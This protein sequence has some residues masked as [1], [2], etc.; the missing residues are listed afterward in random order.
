MAK[1]PRLN[2]IA[3]RMA[4]RAANRIA[5]TAGGPA[6]GWAVTIRRV[7]VVTIVAGSGPPAVPVRRITTLPL[8]RSQRI[9]SRPCAKRAVDWP[10][11]LRHVQSPGVIGAS[12][13][14]TAGELTGGGTGAAA[15][16]GAAVGGGAGGAVQ[17][18][19][20]ALNRAAANN[21][22]GAGRGVAGRGVAGRERLAGT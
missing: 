21:G 17:A 15:G 13:Q 3:S 9:S 5:M 7:E 10:A 12:R 6:K 18:A 20:A 14:S 16:G 11:S 19:S 22:A 1:R 8:L 4:S 2:A